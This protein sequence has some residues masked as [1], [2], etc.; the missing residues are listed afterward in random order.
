MVHNKQREVGIIKPGVEVQ[1]IGGKIE[2]AANEIA[3]ILIKDF[4]HNHG[5]DYVYDM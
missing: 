4:T 2:G 3:G 1:N 5:Y